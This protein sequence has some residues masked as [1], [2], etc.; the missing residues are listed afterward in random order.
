MT[1]KGEATRRRL[2]TNSPD[3]GV[4]SVQTGSYHELGG[5]EEQTE[6]EERG[7]QDGE[8]KLVGQGD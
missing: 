2:E 5:F 6:D 4:T 8:G 1:G 7:V 3:L